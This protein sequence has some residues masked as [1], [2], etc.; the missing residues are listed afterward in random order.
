MK[1][2]AKTRRLC[3]VGSNLVGQQQLLL[4]V[5]STIIVAFAVL[6]GIEGFRQGSVRANQD[7]LVQAAVTIATDIQTEAQTPTTLGGAGIYS[8]S[9]FPG[10]YS[11]SLEEFGYETD[12][13]GRRSTPDGE[14]FIAKGGSN[15]SSFNAGT[16]PSLPG[17]PPIVIGCESDDSAVKVGVSGLHRDDITTAQLT[18]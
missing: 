1:A 15:T 4:L 14:C 9:N 10:S 16:T 7:A 17:N 18:L 13:N 5:L 3:I 8:D 2:K 6:A 11:P 12:G